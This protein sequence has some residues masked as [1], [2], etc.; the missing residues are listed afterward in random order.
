MAVTGH[1]IEAKK[2]K[3]G[4]LVLSFQCALIGFLHIPGRHTGR[5]CAR[6]LF[7]ICERV[8]I[9]DKVSMI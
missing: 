2:G 8:Q 4:Q 6:G 7:F 1:W 3:D 5:H 9:L